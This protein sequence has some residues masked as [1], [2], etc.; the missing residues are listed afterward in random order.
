MQKWGKST[1]EVEAAASAK[2]PYK[3]VLSI[4]KKTVG[5]PGFHRALLAIVSILGIILREVTS[6]RQLFK[7]GIIIII[8]CSFEKDLLGL[9]VTPLIHT[10]AESAQPMNQNCSP[11]STSNT[12]TYTC[13]TYTRMFTA[14][15]LIIA[16]KT[17]NYLNNHHQQ[18]DCGILTYGRL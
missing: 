10:E 12:D 18:V 9:S 5:A 16:K 15:W 13:K 4:F 1:N 17:A 11:S 3:S 6:Q 7:W 14:S 2:I 8:H